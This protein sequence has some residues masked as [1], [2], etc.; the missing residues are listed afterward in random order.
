MAPPVEEQR[1]KD[2]SAVVRLQVQVQAR[3]P[4]HRETPVPQQRT[5]LMMAGCYSILLLLSNTADRR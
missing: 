3:H 1:R 2:G 5:R 4:P